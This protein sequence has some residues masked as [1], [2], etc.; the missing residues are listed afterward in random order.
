MKRHPCLLAAPVFAW[1]LFGIVPAS[2]TAAETHIVTFRRLNGTVLQ[3]AEVAHG[4]AV[5]APE[6]PAEAGFTFREW[7]HADRLA[8]VTNNVTCWALY[9]KEGFPS[10]RRGI[11]SQPVA[12]REQPYSLDELFQLYDNVAWSDEFSGTSIVPNFYGKRHNQSGELSRTMGG[13]NRIVSDGTLKLRVKREES[14]NYHFTA[15]EITTQNMV[16]FRRGR[17]EIRAKLN[18]AKGT[19]PSFW[20]MLNGWGGGY[21]EIDVFEQLSGSEWIGGTLHAGMFKPTFSSSGRGAPEDGVTF[22][23]GFHRIGAIVTDTELVWY[24]DDHIFKRLDIRDRIWHSTLGEKYILLCSGLVAGG[25]LG[26][27]GPE[28]KVT[29]ADDIPAD[30]MQ[31]DY[32]IDY[33]RIYTNTK[34]DNTVAYQ[35]RPDARLSGPVK[36]TVWRGWDMNYG[37]PASFAN[38]INKGYEVGYFIN[39]ALQRY[40]EREN[41]DIVVFLTKPDDPDGERKSAYEIPGKTTVFLDSVCRSSEKGEENSQSRAGIVFDAA[42]FAPADA[43]AATLTL[44][45]NT[46]FATNCF[47]VCADLRERATGARVKV[48]GVNVIS[49][50]GVEIADGAVAKGF[51]ALF[52]K[53]DAM[54]GDCVVLLFQA[55]DARFLPYIKEQMDARLSTGYVFL[56]ENAKKPACQLAYAT[57]NASATATIPEPLS[58]PRKK[59]TES[60]PHTPQALQAT[61]TFQ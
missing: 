1:A 41:A 50:N 55:M 14:G 39:T 52:A 26:S 36:A 2:A 61:V 59:R 33:L 53:L 47:A 29:T 24:V 31:D 11:D 51:E 18:S 60:H 46:G 22:S 20:T 23:Q 58:I 43:G 19:W 40:F 35:A 13:A 15:D 21:N 8:C 25:W 42:R 4:A 45:G 3:T 7:D 9:E 34:S 48:V 30:F 12:A 49:T 16:T 56:G 44:A 54:K 57:A 28:L 10:S 17:I 27:L 37:R 5:A 38:T 6:A 32:E